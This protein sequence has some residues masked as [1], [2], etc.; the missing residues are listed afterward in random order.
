MKKQHEDVSETRVNVRM[1]NQLRALIEQMAREQGRDM[2]WV[3]REIVWAY[4]TVAQKVK[5][6]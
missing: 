4:M 2:A 6:A 5:V 1:N 3:I